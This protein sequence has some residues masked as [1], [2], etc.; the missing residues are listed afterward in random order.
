MTLNYK[1]DG[2]PR[3]SLDSLYRKRTSR[4]WLYYEIAPQV[5]FDYD[6]DYKFNLGIRLRI[7]IFAGNIRS[8]SFRILTMNNRWIEGK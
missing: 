5:S 1:N 4:D 3:F 2:C 8:N 6:Y 7:E